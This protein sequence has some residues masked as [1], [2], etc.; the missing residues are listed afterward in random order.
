M[1]IKITLLHLDKIS[2]EDMSPMVL[3]AWYSTIQLHH[4]NWI[5]FLKFNMAAYILYQFYY[6][7]KS[8]ICKKLT[9]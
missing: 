4:G 3:I 2:M 5:R 7:L 8:N 9:N 6:H 1:S